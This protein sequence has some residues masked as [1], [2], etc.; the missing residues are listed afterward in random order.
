[1]LKMMRRLYTLLFYCGLP[2]IVLRL[3]WKSRQQPAYRQRMAERFARPLVWPQATDVWIHAVSLGEVVAATPLIEALVHKSY[4]VLVT[5]MTP[6][7]SAQVSARFAHRVA[8][9]YIPYDLPRFVRRFYK[10]VNP[11]VGIIMETELWPHLIEQA[12]MAKIPLILVN[13]RLSDGAFRQYQAVR[14]FFQPI[15]RHLTRIFAQ[16][17]QDANRF[18]ALGA[19]SVEMMGQLKCDFVRA[20][21]RSAAVDALREQWGAHRLV[22]IAA[23]THEGEEILWL[24]HWPR[25]LAHDPSAVLFLVP[26]H[27]QRF[28]L[29]HQLSVNQGFKTGLRSQAQSISSAV[30]VVV[31][32]SMGELNDF[33]RI[34]DYAF[35]GG[36]LVPVGG[37]NVLEPMAAKIPVL[38]GPHMHNSRQLCEELVNLGALRQEKDMETLV[39]ALLELH[40]NPAHKNHQIEQATA[41]IDAH[42][43]VVERLM[44]NVEALMDHHG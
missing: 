17:E 42:Q 23:S 34:S 33:Y 36:S 27:P 4:R 10:K 24:K 12:A 29:V 2:F 15:V 35:V 1:M 30:E 19:P 21:T 31:G 14:F 25:V 20:S 7:G 28:T 40:Q 22:V 26:R 43:G 13:A 8:H 32:D 11:R 6:T 38:C 5:T 18:L 3:L 41:F 37:H 9:Q 44:L 39:D 16:S